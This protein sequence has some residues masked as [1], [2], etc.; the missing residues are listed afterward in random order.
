MA[1]VNVVKHNRRALCWVKSHIFH[2]DRNSKQRSIRHSQQKIPHIHY[3]L[4]DS[5]L[6]DHIRVV[7]SMNWFIDIALSI[8]LPVG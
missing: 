3:T 4:Q 2:K 6:I 7:V 1:S 5:L 8:Y